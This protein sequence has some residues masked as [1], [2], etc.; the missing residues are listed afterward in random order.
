MSEQEEKT[1]KEKWYPGKLVA[2]AV[3]ARRSS[4]NSRFSG[5]HGDESPVRTHSQSG[6]DV[7]NE[8]YVD[9]SPN[10]SFTEANPLRDQNGAAEADRDSHSPTPKTE[11]KSDVR[12]SVSAL[13][14]TRHTPKMKK[15]GKI[16][17]NIREIRY[18][19]ITSAKAFVDIDGLGVPLSATGDLPYPLTKEIDFYDI[20]AD[21]KIEFRGVHMTTQQ[22]VVGYVILPICQALSPVG[23]PSKTAT[24]WYEIYPFYDRVKLGESR[25]ITKF[26]TAYPDIPGS[27]LS[28]PTFSLGF[29]QL[30]I[31][32]TLEEDIKSGLSL[33]F[34]PNLRY[35][36][37]NTT[38]P[39][40]EADVQES[41]LILTNARILRDMER[42]RN[43]VFRPF[44]CIAPFLSFPEVF[45]LIVVSL[46]R[47]SKENII[48]FVSC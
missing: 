26:R 23:K 4:L 39:D 15:L 14:P 17:L 28:K 24:K 20:A 31:E 35:P 41:T 2:K 40:D 22:P 1:K 47:F 38:R 43:I 25:K 11:D 3:H 13:N 21:L 36:N 42:I 46:L 37:H 32:L 48:L 16:T 44:S 27:A 6:S 33:Y 7:M 34:Y 12:A 29:L 30:D 19:A 5:S 9:D 8:Y 45:P 18:L 10:D